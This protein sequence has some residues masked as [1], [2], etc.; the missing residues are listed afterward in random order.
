M[1]TTARKR[2]PLGDRHSPTN[3]PLQGDPLTVAQKHDRKRR[4]AAVQRE[5]Q[6]LGYG[7]REARTAAFAQVCATWTPGP[8]TEST[9]P[10]SAGPVTSWLEEDHSDLCASCLYPLASEGPMGCA[11]HVVPFRK[12]KRLGLPEFAARGLAMR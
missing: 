10:I 3:C 1:T 8:G 2:I 12:P 5:L 9:D 6:R 7:N 4:V 11:A